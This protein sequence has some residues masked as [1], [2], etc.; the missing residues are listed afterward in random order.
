MTISLDVN[1]SSYAYPQ[2]GDNN[3]GGNA[4][5]WAYAISIGV[6]QK[7]GGTFTL[8]AEVDFG[9]SYGLKSLYY[10][11]RTSNVAG[12][13]QVRL[14]RADVISWRNQANGANLDL[15]PNSSNVLQFNG[16]DIIAGAI[17]N[18]DIDAAAAIAFSKMAALT[19]SRALQSTAG[20]VVEASSVTS[21]E[22]G[23][24]S[25]VTSAVQTQL[26]ARLP[27]AGGTMTGDLFLNGDPASS[28]QAATKNYVDNA[29]AGNVNNYTARVATTAA[30]NLTNELE[31]G[32]TLDG[33]VLATNDVVLV[34]NQASTADNGLYVVPAAGAASRS[35]SMDTWTEAIGATVFVTAGTVNAGSQ[36]KFNT[37]AGGTLGVT[38]IPIVQLGA[39]QVY[40][41]D[42][43]GLILTGSEFSI[44]IDGTTLSQGGS[45]I[46]VADGGVTNTQ[47]NAAAAIALSK[48]AATTASRA[49]V[50]DGSGFVSAATTTATEI[51]YVNGVTSAIQTQLDAKIAASVMTT[52]GDIIY[53]A[54]GVP[55]RLGIG[56]SGYYLGSDGS[57]PAWNNFKW[58]G[59]AIV[60][61]TSPTSV[62]TTFASLPLSTTDNTWGSPP[63]LSGNDIT[64]IYTGIHKITVSLGRVSSSSSSR[65][66]MV[67]VRNTTDSA[68]LTG[69]ASTS[70]SIDSSAPA[71]ALTFVM[72]VNI[73]NVSKVYQVQVCASGSGVTIN[74]DTINSTTANTCQVYIERVPQ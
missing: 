18:A 13:G 55:A 26:T 60:S 3:W 15:G 7:Q 41:A 47:I 43:N 54:A 14:A 56:T 45:G 73:T 35:T 68:T 64:F 46:K 74:S 38:D 16:E 63:T 52:N 44:D 72:Y 29:S 31:N 20:G 59:I 27:L 21:T 19:A 22:L 53:R 36:W 10:K 71:P 32:D 2:T 39:S 42:G 58:S 11:S 1:G 25:G 51:G 8:T 17:V 61:N 48:L 5:S 30:V 67:R 4:T 23:Y 28:T 57:V 50:S 69:G 66:V 6:L 12:A 37:A 65:R 34:K 49:L 62:G 40:T 9:A 24:L 70:S 33:V